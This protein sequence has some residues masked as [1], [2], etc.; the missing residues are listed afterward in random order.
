[1]DSQPYS[2]PT[3]SDDSELR[4]KTVQR[5]L[6]LA[7]GMLIVFIYV[8]SFAF[9]PVLETVQRKFQNSGPDSFFSVVVFG[10][11]FAIAAGWAMLTVVPLISNFAIV[12][13]TIVALFLVLTA[14]CVWFAGS[15]FMRYGPSWQDFKFATA[16]FAAGVIGGT[17]IVSLIRLRSEW[18]LTGLLPVLESKHAPQQTRV[19]IAEFLVFTAVISILFATIRYGIASARNASSL[20]ILIGTVVSAVAGAAVTIPSLCS[21]GLTCGKPTRRLIVA[22]AVLFVI[23]TTAALIV[24]MFI[25]NQGKFDLA[26]LSNRGITGTWLASSIGGTIWV[27]AVTFAYSKVLNWSGVT[28]GTQTP[29]AEASTE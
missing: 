4:E 23:T 20:Q 22:T 13:R 17:C 8:A 10:S 1:M 9:F 12:P 16:M 15:A 29:T 6:R 7:V 24:T 25:V 5:P 2:P 3:E 19:S 26:T 27:F 18:V 11:F 21:I 14:W 28:L